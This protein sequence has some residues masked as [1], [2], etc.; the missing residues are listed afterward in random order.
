MER[1]DTVGLLVAG[2]LLIGQS[3]VNVAPGGPWDSPSFTRG[4]LGLLGMVLVYLAWF[5]HTFG[6]YGVAPTVN[7]WQTP[8]TTWLRVVVF[9]LACLVVTRAVRLLD[10]RGTVPDPAG[11]LVALVGV[12]AGVGVG[13]LAAQGAARGRRPLFQ[14]RSCDHHP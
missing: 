6:F 5:K 7:R 9:G 8:E 2:A 14:P 1:K 10:D 12:G 11:L 3:F 13:V 4:V